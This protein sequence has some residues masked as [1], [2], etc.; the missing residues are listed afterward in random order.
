MDNNQNDVTSGISRRELL[1]GAGAAASLLAGGMVQAAEHMSADHAHHQHA[2]HAPKHEGLLEAVNH[3]VD[4]GQRCV[5][6]CHVA[7]QEGDVSLA[8][9]AAKGQEMLAVCKGFSYLVTAN[10]VYL[11]DYAQICRQVCLDCKKE[12]EKHDEHRECKACA[13]ACAETVKAIDAVLAA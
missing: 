13:D 2:K 11:K 4:K 8:D 5:F 1:V 9:C 10:S 7:F 12:C 6:H 3:C